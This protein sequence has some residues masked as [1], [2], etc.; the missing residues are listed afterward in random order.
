M[1]PEKQ[2]EDF[3]Y[4]GITYTNLFKFN[5]NGKNTIRKGYN[6]LRAKVNCMKKQNFYFTKV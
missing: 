4:L 3:K 5:I 2:P 1:P 6:I